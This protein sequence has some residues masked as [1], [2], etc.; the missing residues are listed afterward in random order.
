MKA[1]SEVGELWI[2]NYPHSY[3]TSCKWVT[4]SHTAFH[5]LYEVRSGGQEAAK[6]RLSS[7]RLSNWGWRKSWTMRI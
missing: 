1:I 7:L 5:F 3:D 4:D 2:E 6:H